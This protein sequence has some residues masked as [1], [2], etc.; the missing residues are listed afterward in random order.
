MRKISSRAKGST[1]FVVKR[2]SK[3]RMKWYNGSNDRATSTMK[4]R[5]RLMQHKRNVDAK[6]RYLFVIQLNPCIM[7]PTQ[8]LLCKFHVESEI[9]TSVRRCVSHVVSRASYMSRFCFV[10]IFFAGNFSRIIWQNAKT[11][12]IPEQNIFEWNFLISLRR[13]FFFPLLRY[14]FFFR[15]KFAFHPKANFL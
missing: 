9:R 3:F 2:T 5:I 10:P 8:V 1:K 11:W 12:Q 14:W 6:L 7:W 15:R 4:T 13:R